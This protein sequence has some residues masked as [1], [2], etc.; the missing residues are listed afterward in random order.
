MIAVLRTTR[1]GR[2]V[3]VATVAAMLL[4]AF[5]LIGCGGTKESP[6]GP[7]GTG[8]V[9]GAESL[10]APENVR[11][12]MLGVMKTA[13]FVVS[14]PMYVYVNYETAAKDTVIVTGSFKGPKA[15]AFTYAKLKNTAGKWAVVEAR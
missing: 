8:A 12:E 11:T 10:A 7:S 1:F 3:V 5:A 15:E 2:I 9:E 4:A 13:G 14:D 6:G